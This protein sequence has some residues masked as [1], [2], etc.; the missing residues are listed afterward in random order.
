MQNEQKNWEHTEKQR[1]DKVILGMW[2][3]DL[4]V[5]YKFIIVI[6]EAD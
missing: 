3:L 5:I 1:L 2:I 4:S 6:Y